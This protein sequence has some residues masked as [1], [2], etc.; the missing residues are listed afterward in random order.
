M[1][2]NSVGLVLREVLEMALIF[3]AALAIFNKLDIAPRWM[4]VALL[5][6]LVCAG[7]YAANVQWLWELFD[8]TGQEVINGSLQWITAL[9]LIAVAN[10]LS[11]SLRKNISQKKIAL[12]RLLMSL[13]LILVATREG[14]EIIL[15]LLGYIHQPE[16]LPSVLTGAFIGAG[17]GSSLAAISYYLLV[18]ATRPTT[19]NSCFWLML[20]LAAGLTL[21][22][23]KLFTQADYLP[24]TD[25][26]WDS[27][28]WLQETSLAGQFFYALFGYEA[29]PTP[30]EATIY[31]LALGI[32]G[33]Y[34]LYILFL[35]KR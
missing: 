11:G 27:S 3:S 28:A 1:L 8:G 20:I 10:L 9:L 24:S 7:L 22:G 19:L 23:A 18:N 33:L 26:L 17:I 25:A 4:L 2:I 31:M 12:I 21:Q 5:T 34:R 16:P 15:Y 35:E 14:Y 32:P 13:S 6:G 30:A 29:T